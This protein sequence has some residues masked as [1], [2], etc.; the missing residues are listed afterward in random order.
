MKTKLTI[1]ILAALTALLC[2]ATALAVKRTYQGEIKGDESSSVTIK[3]KESDGERALKLFAANDFL[4]AC[5]SGP[6]TL[7]KASIKGLIPVN[8]AGKFSVKGTNGGQELRLSG[9]LVG[10]R[11]AKGS[12]RYSGATPVDGVTENCDSGKLDWRA[13]R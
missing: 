4:I 12:V 3:V 1:T 8:D 11:T 7:E 13:T 10:K 6:A 5:D 2:A 9:K